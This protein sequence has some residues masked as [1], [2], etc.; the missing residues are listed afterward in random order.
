MLIQ[1]ESVPLPDP[2][3]SAALI[4]GVGRY[5]DEKLPDLPMIEAGV[6][7]LAAI[8]TDPVL[9]GFRPDSVTTVV[10]PGDTRGLAR[11]L[12]RLDDVKDTVLVY[13]AGHSFLD[14]RGRLHLGLSGTSYEHLALTALPFETIGDIMARSR[15]AN[16]VLILDTSYSGRASGSMADGEYAV[17]AQTRVSGTYVLT[18]SGRNDVA[19]APIGERHTSFTGSLIEVLRTGVPNGEE[20]LSLDSVYDELRRRAEERGFPVPV[21]GKY[22]YTGRLCLVRNALAPGGGA[23]PD[24]ASHPGETSA[25]IDV[26]IAA[27]APTP[28]WVIPAYAPE[29][30]FGDDVLGIRDD[31]RALAVL[32]GSASV[33]PPVALGLYGE[34]GSGKTFFMHQ[35]EYEIGRYSALSADTACQNVVS[36]WFNAW[37]YA[38]ADLQA[39]LIHHLFSS[40]CGGSSAGAVEMAEAL[41]NLEGTRVVRASAMEKVTAAEADVAKV[42]AAVEAY[43]AALADAEGAAAAL[44]AQDVLAAIEVPQETRAEFAASLDRVGLSEVG[45]TARELETAV[46]EAQA[47]ARDLRWLALTRPWWKSPLILGVAVMLAGEAATVTVAQFAGSARSW[48]AVITVSG[49]VASIGG[50]VAV[51][52][53]RFNGIARRILASAKRVQSTIDARREDLTWQ[54]RADLAAAVQKA[55]EAERVLIEARNDLLVAKQ[56]EALA[57]AARDEL[58]SER[59]LARYLADRAASSDYDRYLGSIALTHRD[60][61]NLDFYLRQ[62]AH[63][64]TGSV[65]D[66]IVLYIDD[67]DRCSPSVVAKVLEAVHLL[68]SLPLFVVVVGVDPR[69]LHMSIQASHLQLDPKRHKGRGKASS[70]D[71]LDKIFQ[72]TYSLPAMT[73]ESCGDLIGRLAGPQSVPAVAGKTSPRREDEVEDAGGDRVWSRGAEPKAAQTIPDEPDVTTFAAQVLTVTEEELTMMR[74]IASTVGSSPRQTKRFLNTYCLVKAR[75]VLDA[76]YVAHMLDPKSLEHLIILLAVL[77]GLPMCTPAEL[78]RLEMEDDQPLREWLRSQ[79]TRSDPEA[80]RKLDAVIGLD[81]AALDVPV[82]HLLPWLPLASRFV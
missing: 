14:G 41:D 22:N 80:T 27:D 65:V 61:R 28:T 73:M 1:G 82:G 81:I 20:A 53:E 6:Q 10:N 59:L 78:G 76:D 54:H 16:R 57:I 18:A 9:G 31:A 66:R 11:A 77:V 55:T 21:F 63:G 39:S 8:L 47:T 52:L 4:I 15:A 69:W 44:K 70:R 19:H 62:A 23:E 48:N 60:L 50:S 51:V 32:L 68:L 58:S 45:T 26:A 74:S 24:E 33:A 35:L 75:A 12:Y 71:Y 49:V 37:Q 67:L 56:R 36:V 29:A 46:Q 34:W 5:E 38:E 30:A 17:T 79:T 43:E 42:R 7:D 40:L 2:E 13:Y 72:L 64:T 25:R 3:R